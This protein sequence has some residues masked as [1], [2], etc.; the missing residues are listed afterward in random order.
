MIESIRIK[1]FQSHEDTILRFSSGVNV[2]VGSSDSGKSAILRAMIWVAQ[3]RPSGDSFMSWGQKETSVTLGVD[4]LQVTRSKGSSKNEYRI[5][6]Q[7]MDQVFTAF[8][9]DVPDDISRILGIEDLNI[10]RQMDAP[11]LL[12]DSSGEVARRLNSVVN[13]DKIHT[14]LS[15]IAAIKRE[16]TRELSFVE[17]EQSRAQEETRQYSWIPDFEA[18]LGVAS[19]AFQSLKGVSLKLS[20]SRSLL[21][22][23]RGLATQLEKFDETERLAA[24]VDK[25][26]SHLSHIERTRKQLDE[27]NAL[28][29]EWTRAKNQKKKLT[30]ISRLKDKIEKAL[31]IHS[32]LKQVI[33]KEKQATSLIY[34][35]EEVSDDL[36]VAKTDYE[37]A[38]R[39]FDEKMSGLRECPL[40]GSVLEA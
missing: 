25:A 33:R 19:H 18:K 11:F 21:D 14:S 6:G 34:Q 9:Q 37:Q 7:E 30:H 35:M 36:R 1:N 32:E 31:G 26:M 13:L 24:R 39:E 2:I 10:Q 17:E 28:I 5:E 22:D 3:N 8:G 29:Q 23:W 15:N 27:I 4:H 12:S 40:C 38:S 20:E 16:E